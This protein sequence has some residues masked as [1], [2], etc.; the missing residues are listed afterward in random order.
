M[1]WQ[2]QSKGTQTMNNVNTCEPFYLV[3]EGGWGKVDSYEAIS[4]RMFWWSFLFRHF[5]LHSAVAR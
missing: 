5:W 1:F 4:N 3:Y 2:T